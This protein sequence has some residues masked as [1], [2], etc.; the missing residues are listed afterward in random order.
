MPREHGVHPERALALGHQVHR[1]P[2][3]LVQTLNLG[4]DA[5]AEHRQRQVAGG[6]TMRQRLAARIQA[7]VRELLGDRTA[8]DDPQRGP[9]EQQDDPKPWI[10]STGGRSPGL[11]AET[12][13]SGLDERN[14]PGEVPAPIATWAPAEVREPP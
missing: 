1:P 4:G 14:E 12:E 11:V 8:S 6:G 3:L 2:G 9:P 10:S 13:S 5:V 7:P